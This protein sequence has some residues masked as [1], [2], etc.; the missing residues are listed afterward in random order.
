MAVCME[1]MRFQS[2]CFQLEGGT[3]DIWEK[4]IRFPENL[5]QS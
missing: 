3:P 2:W 5:F 1:M 4:D